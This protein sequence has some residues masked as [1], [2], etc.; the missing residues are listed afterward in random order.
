[1]L[2]FNNGR[3]VAIA[4]DKAGKELF[5]IHVTEEKE[6]PDIQ[7][8]DTLSLIDDIDIDQLKRSLRMGKIEENVLKRLLKERKNK[9]NGIDMSGGKMDLSKINVSDKIKRALRVLEDKANEKLKT[10]LDFE[11]DKSVHSVVPLIGVG[12]E[13]FDRS[14][15]LCAPSGAGKTWMVKLIIE[16][17]KKK[18]PVVLFSKIPDD[19]SLKSLEGLKTP[20][21]GKERLIKIPLLCEDDLMDLPVE[22]D[23]RDTI[24][25]FDDIDAFHS[26]ISQ[27]IREYRDSLL[28]AG[29]HKNITCIC[30]SHLL[31]NYTKTK[32]MLNEAELVILFPNSNRRHASTFLSNRLGLDKQERDFYINKA[33]KAGRYLAMKMS[34]PNML[35][36]NKGLLII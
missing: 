7:V 6:L 18:R 29:R 9:K 5:T 25:V 31:N 28:E 17:D 20:K 14:I 24:C 22:D 11:G 34:A 26:D 3:K 21:D 19:D 36:H 15:F 32:I 16:Q 1:M 10:E 2:S 4:L 23:L 27:Y 12:K 33:Q 13:N 35:I 30:T 8:D